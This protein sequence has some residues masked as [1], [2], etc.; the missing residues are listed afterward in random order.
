MQHSVNMPSMMPF[1]IFLPVHGEKY[2][3]I[4]PVVYIYLEK[5]IIFASKINIKR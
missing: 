1:W 4:L 2:R 3:I 5:S